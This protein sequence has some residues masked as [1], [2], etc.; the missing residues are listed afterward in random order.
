MAM[1]VGPRAMNHAERMEISRELADHAQARYGD[2]ILA[3]GLYGSVARGT[4]GPFSDIEMLCVLRTTG[5]QFSFEWSTGPW[6]AEVDFSSEDV[7]LREAAAVDGTWPLTHGAFLSILPLFDP[8]RFFERLLDVVAGQPEEKF[9]AAIEETLVGELY[10]FVGKLRNA[11]A[12]GNTA[13]IPEL[14]VSMARYGAYVLG[15]AHRYTYSTGSRALAEALTLPDRPAGFD[16]L[17]C[18]VMSG[19]LADAEAVAAA[20]EAFWLGLTAWADLHGFRMTETRR[21]PF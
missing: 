21:I 18:L 16:A 19:N 17:C 8:E 10:E 14:A 9:R 11:R 2:R 7:V 1:D 3:I 12:A 6:K 5:E 13:Y 20:C 15:L 4:D